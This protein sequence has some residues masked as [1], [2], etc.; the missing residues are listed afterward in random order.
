[1]PL[2]V[3]RSHPTFL[4]QQVISLI[5]E[6]K[7]Q[8]S[9]KPG[10]KLPSLRSLA[11]KLNL[12][13]PTVQQAYQELERIGEVEARPKSGYYLKAESI[14]FNRPKRIE[15]A[16]KP[17]QVKRQSLIEQ[18]YDAIHQPGN[19]PLG[20]ANP[21]AAYPSDK[22]LARIMRKVMSHEG[23]K[24]IAYGPMDGHPALKRQLSV[25]Y[26][27]FGLQLSPDDMV[28]TNGAQEA[29]AIALQC[30]AKPGDII[31]VES[32]CYFGILEL[33]E[34]LGMMAYEIP[35][36]PDDGLWLDDLAQSLH[37][38]P[39]QACI[40][41]TSITNPMGSYM[42]DERRRQLVE[43]LEEQ[44]IPLIED[45]VYGDLYFT[46]KRGTPAQYYSKKGL[47]ITCA[48]F[49]KTAAPSY[50]VGWL[51]TSKYIEK[52][53]RLKRALSCS[54]PLINQKTLSEFIASGEYDRAMKH[55]RQTLLCNRDRM[56]ALI[57]QHFP[58][59]IRVSEPQGG[60]VLWVEL[61]KHCDSVD[62]F[63]RALAQKIS[64]A[65]GVIFS[66]SNQYKSCFRI[67]YGLPW[68]HELEAAV[69]ALGK[70]LALMV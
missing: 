40:F 48:S 16:P 27:D 56:I 60:A 37:D 10:D 15:R 67:S 31:A 51:I 62:L 33:I 36:C 47:V 5:K 46:N 54:T 66:P 57:Q 4:Y 52:A 64:I 30:V 34:S 28:I 14:E 6:M 8:A 22:A 65:P 43:L 18:V 38:H 26:L 2:A 49:S 13:V 59:N 44:Q 12:S 7:Q 58:E 68:N 70:L 35:L 69:K 24:A 42:P 32:P 45:D 20:I 3:E 55:L 17:V 1:M 39:I 50:R 9:L 63:Y 23:A 29:L 41:S 11:N 53:R 25:R 21:V 61:P 19:L